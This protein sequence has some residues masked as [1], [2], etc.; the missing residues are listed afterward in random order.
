MSEPNITPLIDVMLVLIIIFMV[1]NPPNPLGLDALVPQPNPNAEPP[2][3]DVINRT[4][5]VSIED[6]YPITGKVNHVQAG[7]YE[8]DST[9]RNHHKGGGCSS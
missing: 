2:S 4:V 8:H 5:V 6:E 1:I 9:R 3:L 7:G